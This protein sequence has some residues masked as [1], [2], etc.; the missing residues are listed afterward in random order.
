[1]PHSLSNTDP[2]SIL[3]TVSLAQ[4]KAFVPFFSSIFAEA[5]SSSFNNNCQVAQ[6]LLNLNRTSPPHQYFSDPST[7]PSNQFDSKEC[8]KIVNPSSSSSLS[9]DFS[10]AKRQTEIPIAPKPFGGHTRKR[11]LNEE[12][13]KTRKVRFRGKKKNYTFTKIS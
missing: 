3:T 4:Q 12:E 7:S 1:M 9:E 8:L 5:P 13:D 10:Q 6:N 2:F 11:Q